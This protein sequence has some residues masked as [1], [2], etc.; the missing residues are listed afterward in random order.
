MN[1]VTHNVRKRSQQ[2][3]DQRN[4]PPR[5]DLKVSEVAHTLGVSDK[6]VRGLIER[7]ELPAYRYGPR[8]T[9]VRPE[10]LDAF[11]EAHRIRPQD[12]REEASQR[13][14]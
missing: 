3:M 1:S 13:A 9:R 5:G 6:Q 14:G 2:K 7:G 11:R 10:D 8:G 12:E 4:E